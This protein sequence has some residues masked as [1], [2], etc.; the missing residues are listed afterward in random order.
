MAVA[1]QGS[2]DEGKRASGNLKIK[3]IIGAAGVVEQKSQP[4]NYVLRASTSPK[5]SFTTTTTTSGSDTTGVSF[6]AASRDNKRNLDDIPRERSAEQ[7]RIEANE[8]RD[9]YLASVCSAT[10]SESQSQSQSREFHC[11]AALVTC[12][13]Q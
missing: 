8:E 2:Q 12:A 13:I 11:L 6:E 7:K 1:R 3:A 4:S 5:K 10:K 9:L